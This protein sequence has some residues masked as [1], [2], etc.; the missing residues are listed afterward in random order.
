[1]R[2]C[3][4]PR[5]CNK[6]AHVVVALGCMCHHG[7]V[8]SWNDTPPD[9]E[10]LVARDFSSCRGQPPGPLITGENHFFEKI[11]KR[12]KTRHEPQRHAPCGRSPKWKGPW[13][14]E[15]ATAHQT[16][17]RGTPGASSRLARGP[18]APS[19]GSPP[20]SRPPQTHDAPPTRALKTLARRGRP[21]QR[22]IP[23][24]VGMLSSMTLHYR[25]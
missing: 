25:H 11:M 14:K 6:V 2:S 23:A 10:D 22:R 15:A 20:R 12:N 19:G 7:S 3:Y 21:G 9:I 18:D 8:L 16:I 13:P 1:L 17:G 4:C 5:E 24:L